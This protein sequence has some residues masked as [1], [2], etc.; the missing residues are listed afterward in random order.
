MSHRVHSDLYRVPKSMPDPGDG[1][2]IRVSEDLQILEMVSAGAETRTLAAPTKPGIRVVLRLMT[3]GGDLTVEAENGFNSA[4]DTVATF[5]DVGDVLSLI[6]V[7]TATG[8][9][10][11]LSEGNTGVALA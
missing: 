7:S 5:A 6:S 9:R 10:W 4:G 8:Y 2:T 11:E 1:G 3:D